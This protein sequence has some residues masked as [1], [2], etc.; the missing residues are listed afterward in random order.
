MGGGGGYSF[1]VLLWAWLVISA[2]DGKDGGDFM[3]DDMR[4]LGAAVKDMANSVIKWFE[5]PNLSRILFWIAIIAFAITIL[6]SPL[7]IFIITAPNRLSPTAIMTHLCF[8]G[9][10]IWI[11]IWAVCCF[12]ICARYVKIKKDKSR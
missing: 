5:I 7:V 9:S 10:V 6:F 3:F 8:L 4:C 1:L 12:E 11:P 2:K